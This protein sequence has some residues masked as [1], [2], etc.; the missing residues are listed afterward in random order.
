[1]SMMDADASFLDAGRQ[2]RG[3]RAMVVR[4][5][6]VDDH[7]VVRRGIVELL[8]SDSELE[9]VGEAGSVAEAMA[10]IPA[11]QPDVAVLDVRLPDGSGV[12]LCREL[13]SDLPEH[14]FI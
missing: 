13:L 14:R 11:V 6:L 2:R 8:G 7:E 1:M 3:G 5:F 4:V 10:R 9:V 12:E